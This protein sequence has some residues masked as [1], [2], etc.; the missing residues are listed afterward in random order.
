M[1][2]PIKK[3]FFGNLNRGSASVGTDDGLGGEGI[4]TTVVV[5][6]TGSNYSQGATV[7]FGTPQ[8]PTGVGATGS[9]TIA[10]PTLGGGI[11]AVTLTEGGSGYTTTATV[12]V[13]TASSVTKVS[14]GTNATTSI[15]VASTS[16]IFVGM[17]ITGDAG[18]G[19]G[20]NTAKVTAIGAGTVTVTPAHDGSFAGV[21]L[22]FADAGTG[23]VAVTSRTT[24]Q[25]NAL[26]VNAFVAGGSSGVIGDIVKQESSKRYLVKTAQAS[27]V[28]SQCKLVAVATGSLVEGE[29]NIVASDTSSPAST[30]YVTKLTA[31]RAVLTRAANGGSGYEYATGAVA[32]WTT[33]TASTGVVSIGNN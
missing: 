9:L 17:T 21:T 26:T 22:T 16:G 14:S 12:T 31:H 8:L 23:F 27:G 13:T 2:R 30:Y 7:A 6:S 33:S 24:S 29:M 20:S 25:I 19:G 10:I 11:T 1:G 15:Q 4:S 28:P 18:L 5:N 3:Q 32:G